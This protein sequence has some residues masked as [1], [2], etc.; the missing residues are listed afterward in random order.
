MHMPPAFQSK[1]EVTDMAS[2]TFSM[3]AP[4]DIL[5]ERGLGAGGAVQSYIDG[6]ILAYCRCV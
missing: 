1:R 2:V 6:Q 4:A 3:K 5:R